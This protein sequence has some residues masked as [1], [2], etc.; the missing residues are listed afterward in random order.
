MAG[1]MGDTRF[2]PFS[3]NTVCTVS[4]DSSPPMAL[5]TYTPVRSPAPSS[6][7]KPAVVHRFLAGSDGELAKAVGAANVVLVQ[8]LGGVE[9]AG[10]TGD[11]GRVGGGVEARDGADARLAAAKPLPDGLDVNPERR[12]CA[13][14]L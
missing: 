9:F 10:F 5:P 14:P 11:T 8:I 12:H 3:R 6:T 4:R 2:G 13:K 7:S 1:N